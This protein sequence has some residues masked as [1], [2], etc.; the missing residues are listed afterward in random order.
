MTI[1]PNASPWAIAGIDA[2]LRELHGDKLLSMREIADRISFEFE[3]G[4]SRNAVIGR[5]RRI[6]LPKRPSGAPRSPTI[7]PKRKPPVRIDAPI[8]PAIEP[9]AEPLPPG[10]T[11][12]QL[13]EGVCKFP[14]PQAEDHPPYF[15]CGKATKIDRSWCDEH[16][17]RVHNNPLRQVAP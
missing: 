9:V 7:A 1:L 13:R 3:V 8:A 14:L 2:R 5:A 4:I 16:F 11:I 12:Y 17:R 10:L 6:G 15:Y